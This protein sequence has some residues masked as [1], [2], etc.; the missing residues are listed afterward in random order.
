MEDVLREALRALSSHS[1]WI[2]W[3]L[4]LAFIPLA[5][6]FWLFRWRQARTWFWWIGLVV[7]IA[8]LPNAP[9]LLTDVVHLIRA[10]QAGYSTWV[11]AVFMIP[12][13]ITAIL[14]GTEAYVMAV[15]NQSYYLLQHR[16]QRFVLPAE[17]LTHAL[18]AVGVYLGRFV[19]FNSWDLVTRPDEVLI[20]TLDQ[21][22]S[23]RPLVVMFGTFV[24]LTVV[25]WV[26][27][28][29]TIG[30]LLRVRYARQGRNVFKEALD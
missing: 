10:T 12:V 2:L 29:I 17:L 14:L 27:K 22:T 8:F 21:L 6:S 5:L 16:A 3:N 1:R 13:H 9:Y 23:E 11:I 4:F 15:I 20:I 19:R 28:Q 25:Y 18:C 26:L 30:L 7:F 24:I